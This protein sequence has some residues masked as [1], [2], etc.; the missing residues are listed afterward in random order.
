MAKILDRLKAEHAKIRVAVEALLPRVARRPVS[1]MALEETLHMLDTRLAVHEREEEKLFKGAA[2]DLLAA[3]H[4]AHELIE[5][6]RGM[7]RNGLANWD[8][9][10]GGGPLAAV[11]RDALGDQ[12]EDVLRTILAQFEHEEQLVEELERPAPESEATPE[13]KARAA[14]A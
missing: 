8:M 2:P 7:L 13:A 5:T 9:P 3:V 4:A 11:D 1:R 12:A 14:R 6:G 10:A